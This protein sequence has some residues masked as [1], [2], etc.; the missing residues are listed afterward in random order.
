MN[1]NKPAKRHI[2]IATIVMSMIS[3]THITYTATIWD[4]IN[5]KF[6]ELISQF[7]AQFLSP[8]LNVGFTGFEF[9]DFL[10]R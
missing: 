7:V 1:G 9:L 5:A 6:L 2:V 8:E 4:V 3:C 10:L